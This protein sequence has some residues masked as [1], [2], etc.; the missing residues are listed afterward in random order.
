M[1]LSFYLSL[2]VLVVLTTNAQNFIS[3]NTQNF[4]LDNTQ[5]FIS[6][7][8]Q[9][10]ISDN[11][12]NHI[13]NNETCTCSCEK[14]M[15]ITFVAT[16][17]LSI[18][19]ETHLMTTL[20]EN[21]LDVLNK[22]VYCTSQGFIPKQ[23]TKDF[24]QLTEHLFD[25]RMFHQLKMLLEYNFFD[26]LMG[27]INFVC[28]GSE[29]VW[30]ADDLENESRLEFFEYLLASNEV[31]LARL[32]LAH[33]DYNNIFLFSQ[34]FIKVCVFSNDNLIEYFLITA[35]PLNEEASIKY[36]CLEFIEVIEYY[37]LWNCS[38]IMRLFCEN[39]RE[40]LSDLKKKWRIK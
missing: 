21:G 30:S 36:E 5:N 20:N 10:F 13:S 15:G 24:V 39:P 7:N 6:D 35:E 25:R 1:K 12:Q 11:T 18:L 2:F 8:T 40:K 27:E 14:F 4:T 29:W 28:E 16:Q 17:D 34:L 32:I 37:G 9:N 33:T 3:D 23:N 26:S 22:L 19:S 31:G 38:K